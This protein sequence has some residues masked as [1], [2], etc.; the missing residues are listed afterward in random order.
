MDKSIYTAKEIKQWNCDAE[1]KGEWIPARPYLSLKL[2]SRLKAA[3]GVLT[4][5]YDALNWQDN[6]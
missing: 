1:I 2:I 4:G 5:K 3:Y 6:Q